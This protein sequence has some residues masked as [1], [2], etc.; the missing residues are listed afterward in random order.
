LSLRSSSTLLFAR[1]AEHAVGDADLDN[2]RAGQER[3]GFPF[4]GMGKQPPRTGAQHIG[5][6][7]VDIVRLTKADNVVRLDY[8]VLLSVRGSGRLAIDT[9]P[10][11]DRR[12]AISRIA[13]T[14]PILIK[15]GRKRKA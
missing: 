13:Q 8:G 3:L 6:G 2:L 4:N 5:D 10:L 11:N 12:H 9:A 7:I 1:D 14:E 15:I